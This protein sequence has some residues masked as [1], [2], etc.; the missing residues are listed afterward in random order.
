MVGASRTGGRRKE[1]IIT[2]SEKGMGVYFREENEWRPGGSMHGIY[3]GID[4]WMHVVQKENDGLV[5]N[6][7]AFLASSSFP[8]GDDRTQP[9]YT[10][11]IKPNP[12]PPPFKVLMT[13][14]LFVGQTAH[15]LVRK[16]KTRD[17][18]FG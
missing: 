6:S 18:A 13:R 2:H 4:Q 15:R 7:T 9:R 17:R 12:A 16:P 11:L 5:K 14:S 1:L 8:S 3:H 10:S